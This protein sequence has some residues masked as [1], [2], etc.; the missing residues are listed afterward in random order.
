[1]KYADEMSL[2]VV[3]YEHT[4][5]RGDWLRHAEVGKG[6]VQTHSEVRRTETGEDTA[7][8]WMLAKR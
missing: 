1:M 7:G 3:I 4:K 6:Y 5:F 2:S 8:L